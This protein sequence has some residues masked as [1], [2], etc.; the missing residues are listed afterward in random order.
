MQEAVISVAISDDGTMCAAGTV[1]A[2]VLIFATS[3]NS[4]VA[5]YHTKSGVN[6]V[7][8]CGSGDLCSLVV[9]T[10]SGVVISYYS[11]TPLANGEAIPRDHR[12]PPELQF[13]NKQLVHCMAQADGGSRLAVGGHGG[14]V[15]VYSVEL[16]RGRACVLH[17]LTRFD[18]I[19][20]VQGMAMNHDASIL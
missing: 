3:D 4:E 2:K 15:T 16:L 5:S 18:A 8:F 9:G 17:E 11:N 12:P 6:A 1:G 10:L 14:L 19:G 7:T 13:G 20:D